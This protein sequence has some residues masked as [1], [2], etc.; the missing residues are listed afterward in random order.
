MKSLRY[1]LPIILLMASATITT[2]CHRLSSEAKQMIGDYYITDISNDLPVLELKSNGSV[3]QRAIKPGVLTY[4]VKG[5]WNV[6]NDSLVIFDNDTIPFDIEGDSTL[7]GDI[8]QRSSKAIVNFNGTSL[9]L[10]HD[11]ADY[12]YY[13]RGHRE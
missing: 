10:R 4:S 7:I 2:G 12:V 1:S 13:R 11:G 3:V 6:V 8:P 5:R 9:T